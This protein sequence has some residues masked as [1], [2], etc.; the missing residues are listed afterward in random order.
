MDKKQQKEMRNLLLKAFEERVKTK[1]QTGAALLFLEAH[2]NLSGLNLG[3]YCRQVIGCNP[4]TF[5]KYKSGELGLSLDTFRRYMDKAAKHE[6]D[7]L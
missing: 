1:D 7:R 2:A 5:S 4:A 6:I 3:K